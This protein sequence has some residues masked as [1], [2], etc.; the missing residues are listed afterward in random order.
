[1][2]VF[3]RRNNPNSYDQS[4]GVEPIPDIVY[5]MGA[6]A[7]ARYVAQ[8][9]YPSAG[10]YNM[11]A[12]YPAVPIAALD[13][14]YLEEEVEERGH[15]SRAS[16]PMNLIR[17]VVRSNR[18]KSRNRQKSRRNH[19]RFARA[20]SPEQFARAGSPDQFVRSGSP[21]HFARSVRGSPV[22]FG[23]RPGSPYLIP[24]S[25]PIPSPIPFMPPVEE[26]LVRPVTPH[27]GVVSSTPADVARRMHRAQVS[28][29]LQRIERQQRFHASLIQANPLAY[30]TPYASL[31]PQY[32]SVAQQVPISA[33]VYSYY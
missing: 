12:L 32:Y 3:R 26:H 10:V 8:N 16:S 23:A 29:D 24:H 9:P 31:P 7:A 14:A 27:V 18:S 11:P 20:G 28:Q 5:Q 21:E 13:Q 6:E 4:S 17:S 30:R 2:R 33:P 22:H 1:M 19:D 25:D 15:R